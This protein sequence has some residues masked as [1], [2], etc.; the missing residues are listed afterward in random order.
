MKL[1]EQLEVIDNSAR[2]RI[3]RGHGTGAD[4]ENE[5]KSEILFCN[6]KGMIQHTDASAEWLIA[7]PPV[8]HFGAKLEIRHREYKIRGLMPP[9]EPELTRQYEFKDLTVF[10][11]YNIYI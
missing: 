6:Y 7:D 8:V 9:Y 3:I 5:R 11:Y 10:L 1:S 4:P 2:I